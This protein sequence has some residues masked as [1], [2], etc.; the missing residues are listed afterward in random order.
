ME[1]KIRQLKVVIVDDHKIIRDGLKAILQDGNIEVVGEAENGEK[2]LNTLESVTPDLVLLDINMPGLNGLELTP[3]LLERYPDIKI[4]I[5]SMYND[6]QF[7]ARAIESGAMGYVLKSTGKDELLHA[8]QTAASGQPYVC[9]DISL[10]LVRKLSSH[11]E[12]SDPKVV[13]EE[14]HLTPRE[15]EVLKLIADGLTNAEIADKLFTSRRTV[16][17]HRQ[18]LIEKTHSKNTATLI[19]FALSQGI[20]D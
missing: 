9:M 13:I 19:R 16:E 3:I 7:I 10:D 12:L 14:Y 4:L 5:L 15:L 8:I 18:H 11:K 1:D 20:I 17:S 2:L 6:N